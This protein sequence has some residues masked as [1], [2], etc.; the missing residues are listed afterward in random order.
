MILRILILT[1]VTLSLTTCP[2]AEPAPTSVKA[3]MFPLD[4]AILDP[5][6]QADAQSD[7]KAKLPP[8]I[9]MFPA[10]KDK[11]G[12]DVRGPLGRLEALRGQS[13]L[14]PESN[15][16]DGLPVVLRGLRLHR[17]AKND[18]SLA[19]YEVELQGEF[20]SVKVPVEEKA[21]QAFLDGK[22]A[23]FSLKGEKNYGLFSYVS[24][25]KLELQRLDDEV[26]IRKLEGDF[27]FRE[28]LYTYTSKTLKLAPPPGR[29]YLYRGRQE[30]LPALP[31]I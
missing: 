22:P 25:T 9:V 14:F 19:G 30:K 6:A 26:V 13:K 15:D 16:D 31:S 8:Y 20:N 27:S 5:D 11:D 28:G 18:G 21:M 24:T 1:L 17:Q 7:E 4:L 29:D 23:T 3:A 10:G 2:A 12:R